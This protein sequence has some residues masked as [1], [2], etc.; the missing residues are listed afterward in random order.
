V[1][2]E[3]Y[4]SEATDEISLSDDETLTDVDFT[5]DDGIIIPNPISTGTEDVFAANLKVYPNPFTDAIH[6]TGIVETWRISTSLN[7]RA[8]SLRVINT[9][10]AI[11]YTRMITHS[12]ETIHLGHLPAGMYIIRLEN[13][14]MAKTV[15]VI[16]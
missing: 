8:T 11:V 7:E 6:I 14:R 16:K 10:G 1:E 12:D 2:I 5:V 4:E 9:A 13:G 15:K 3:K